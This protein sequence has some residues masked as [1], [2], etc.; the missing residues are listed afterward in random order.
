MRM[1]CCCYLLH[2]MVTLR[3]LI[4][5]CHAAHLKAV[6][7]WYS[8]QNLAQLRTGL[9]WIEITTATCVDAEGI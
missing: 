7:S 1:V 3:P 2:A 6:R 9:H 4:D 5:A 8:R